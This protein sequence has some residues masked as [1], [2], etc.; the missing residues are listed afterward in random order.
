M[1]K[2][3]GKAARG[4]YKA[5]E[6]DPEKFG[7]GGIKLRQ[8]RLYRRMT[9]ADLADRAG[10]STGTITDIESGKN[11]WGPVTLLKLADALGTSP[12]GLLGINPLKDPDFWAV[13]SGATEPQ[14]RRI[15]DFAL[16]IEAGQKTEE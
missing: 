3:P 15:T 16:G 8:W 9:V 2:K 5:A 1:A 12:A 7:K 4:P 14:R 13:W 6:E 11:G 10:L